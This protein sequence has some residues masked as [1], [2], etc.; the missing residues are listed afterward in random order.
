[1]KLVIDGVPPWDGE[2]EM[3]GLTFT[4]R[5]MHRIKVISGLRGSE[6]VEALTADDKGGF[7]AVAAVVLERVGKRPDLDEFWDAKSGSIWIDTRENGKGDAGPPEPGSSDG[8]SSESS[9]SEPSSG[10]RSEGSGE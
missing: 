9:G 5:E 4:N 6:V 1:M 10:T 2:Y 3:D 8:S 7:V